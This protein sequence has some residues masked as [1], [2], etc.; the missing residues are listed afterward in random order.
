MKTKSLKKSIILSS[1][2]TL[3]SVVVIVCL[4]YSTAVN[5]RYFNAIK[6]DFYHSVVAQSNEMDSWLTKHMTIV[7]DLA[8]TA[9]VNDLHGNEL[10]AYLQNCVSASSESILESYAAWD[11]ETTMMVTAWVDP[12]EGF[13]AQERGWY[14]QAFSSGKTILTDPYIDAATGKIVISIVTP[15]VQNGATKG[16]CGIDV[17]V[18]ELIGIAQNL[19]IDE[20]GYVVLIDSSNNI[21]IHTQNPEYNHQLDGTGEKVT[22]LTDLSDIY[23]DILNSIESKEVVRCNDYDGQKRFFP[24]VE[25]GDTGWKIMYAADYFEASKTI[26][27]HTILVVVLCVA[28][29]IIGG[30]FLSIKFTKR[31]NSLTGISNIVIEMASG[32]LEHNYPKA[33]NDE[34]GVICNSLE[35]T[36]YALKSYINSIDRQLYAMSEGDFSTTEDTNFVG[37]FA[38]IGESLKNIQAALSDTFSQINSTAGQISAGSNG[39][40]SGAAELASAV[41]EETTLINEVMSDI[42]DIADKVSH[43]ADNASSAKDETLN[44][45]EVIKESNAKMDELLNAMNDIA[46]SAEKIVKINTTIEDIAFQTNILALNASVEAARAGEAGKG[47]AVVADEVRNLANKSSESSNT[48][49][50]LITET[51]NVIEK[52]KKLANETAAILS[53]VVDKTKVI[54]TSVTEISD[55]TEAQKFQLTDIV[56]KLSTVSGVVQTTAATAEESAAASEE[57]DGQVEMLRSSLSKY[58]I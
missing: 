23:T 24:I 14:K 5:I 3:I 52:G 21:V 36:N 47:F 8:I 51:V 4:I 32:K 37:E 16:C 18:T 48:T 38:A 10:K 49:S 25:L 54:E 7:E 19:K 20:N 2:G 53:E 41:S 9:A 50:Q 22:A 34:I 55:V 31:L 42:E 6:Q 45:V 27:D 12:P 44:T 15:I 26:I 40:A 28:G 11:A 58:K 39:V 29:M 43:S 30:L 17:D 33:A 13:V 35:Q 1:V 57:L 56:G 46:V